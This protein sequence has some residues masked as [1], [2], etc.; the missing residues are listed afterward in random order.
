[1]RNYNDR[2]DDNEEYPGDST[3]YYQACFVPTGSPVSSTF[4]I[5]VVNVHD[6]LGWFG[7]YCQVEEGGRIVK[8]P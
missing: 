2:E 1:M 8:G 7:G 6:L 3:A 4:D 5:E